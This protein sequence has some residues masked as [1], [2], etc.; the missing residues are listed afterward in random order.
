MANGQGLAFY[1][2]TLRLSLYLPWPLALACVSR[3]LTGVWSLF[4]SIQSVGVLG[5]GL[6]GAGIAQVC[7]QSGLPHH[8]AGGGPGGSRQGARARAP[9]P[10]R[11]RAEGKGDRRDA[12]RDAGEPVGHDG[13]RRARGCD[14]VIEAIVENL[15]AKRQAYAALEAVVGRDT[16]I[17]LEHLVAVH[18]GAG[19][20]HDAGPIGSAGCTSSTRCR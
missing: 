15:E 2:R 17:V 13:R 16:L 14:L 8:R 12:R 7:A 11:G 20:R 9:I 5:C 3:S 19:G 1:L 18:H 4:M 6:M 10:R